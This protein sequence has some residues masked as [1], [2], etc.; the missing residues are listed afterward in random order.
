MSSSNLVEVVLLEE[1]VYGETPVAGDFQ[2]ARFISEG[3]SGTAETTES[4]QIRTDRMS[5]GQVVTSLTVGGD[6]A[7]EV[8]KEPMLDSL[9]ASAMQN[10]WVTSA[11]ITTDLTLNFSAKTLERGAGDFNAEVRVGDVLELDGFV[12]TANNTQI[13][14]AQIISATEIRFVGPLTLVDE[15][16]TGNTFQVADYL[17][18]GIDK[19]SYSMQK[20]FLDLTDKA[21]NYR[22]MVV[23][24]L[25]LNVAYGEIVKGSVSFSGNDYVPV[26]LASDFMTDGRT[27]LPPATTN[28]LNGSVDMPLIASSAIGTLDSV[29]FCIQKVDLK[30][31]NNL[32]TQTCIGKAAPKDYS[33]GT[34]NIGVSLSA[35]L[36]DNNW[37]MLAKKLSQESFAMFFQLK[38]LDGWYSFYLPA[39]QVSFDDPSSQGQ[40]QDVTLDMDGSAKVGATG[41]SAIR[42]YRS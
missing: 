6:L 24:D 10:D 30:L 40:N 29:A 2:T 8:A 17:E 11:V 34:A 33:L 39:I 36:A 21:I 15:V 20:R 9:L 1:T 38:N 27:V 16:G 42:I 23:S 3:L 22:G 25:E 28:S 19:K 18:I 31:A 13:V 37:A 4:Q 5:S 26:E 32:S 12:A 7:F 41:E 14:V 35:Y